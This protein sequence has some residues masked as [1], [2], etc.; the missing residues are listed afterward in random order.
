VD[1]W[2]PPRPP[3]TPASA[4]ADY[5]HQLDRWRRIPFHDPGLPAAALPPDWPGSAAWA[6]FSE[7]SERLGPAAREH[8]EARAGV[9]ARVA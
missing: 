3:P 5:L 8:V 4:F 9:R 2:G 6:L 7:L 1:T